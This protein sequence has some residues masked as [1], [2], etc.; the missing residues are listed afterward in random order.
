[1]LVALVMPAAPFALL[2]MKVLL[3]SLP[4]WVFDIPLLAPT[5]VL[6][7]PKTFELPE[8]LPKNELELP[9]LFEKP[10]RKPKNAFSWLKVLGLPASTP[11][12]RFFAVGEPMLNTPLPP[13][14]N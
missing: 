11:T 10:E 3:L 12:E 8:L 2:P 13:M 7:L 4:D 14:L 6:L 5:K 9:R 1:M